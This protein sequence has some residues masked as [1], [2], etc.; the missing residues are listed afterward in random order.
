VAN[1]AIA[2]LPGFT[3][4]GDVSGSDKSY[5]EDIVEPAIRADGG[6]I[7]VPDRPGTGFEP[8]LERI[9]ARTSRSLILTA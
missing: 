9:E 5:R 1:I 4:P 7:S 8:I 2:S 3:L 6:R